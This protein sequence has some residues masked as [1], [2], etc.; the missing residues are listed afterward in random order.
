[1]SLARQPIASLDPTVVAALQA[2]MT[3]R[4]Q[5]AFPTLDFRR[6][7]FHDRVLYLSAVLAADEQDLI[8]RVQQSM[9][10][11]DI[12]ANPALADPSLVEAVLSNF[13]MALGTGATASGN[14]T[15]VVS[16]LAPLTIPAGMTFTAGG[17]TLQ[18]ASATAVRTDVSQVTSAGDRVLSRQTD[19]NYAFSLPAAASAV[20]AAGNLR[21]GTAAV[22]DQAPPFFVRAY[23]QDDWT[24]GTDA[25]TNAAA[26]ARLQTGVAAPVFSNRS[27]IAAMVGDDPTFSGLVGL[28]ILGSSDVEMTRARHGL[29]PVALP[30]YC[31][32]L[33]RTASLPV[34]TALT[35]T[36]SLV[37]KTSQG[38]VWQFSVGRDDAPGFYQATQ[39]VPFGGDTTASGY[40]IVS[41]V[42]GM[43]GAGLSY[44]PDIQSAAEAA[45]TRYQTAVIQFLDTD[46]PVGSLSVGAT[47]NYTVV[48]SGQPLLAELQDYLSARSRR[49]PAGDVLVRAAVPCDLRVSAT[50]YVPA[51][52]ASPST[53]SIAQAMAGAVNGAGFAGA[54]YASTLIDACASLMPAGAVFGPI[55][56]FGRIRRPDGVI[57]PLRNPA[58]LQVPSDPVNG[59]SPRTVS[60]LLDPANI[61][62]TVATLSTP[63]I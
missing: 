9:S 17:V 63:D 39:I 29:F 37:S 33:A 1:M 5:A 49:S 28:S 62:L 46:T 31:D 53:S 13:R 42:R 41:D 6:G 40:G 51:G 61:S 48:L 7:V 59:V 23:V 8:D 58:V 43:D 56:L 57:V 52:S 38:G 30:G 50:L 10:L 32:I 44:V 3:A 35:K 16:A 14:L 2:D 27:N 24:G 21:R 19:G 4:M 36:A 22:P 54:L 45:Y 34:R 55:D 18:T 47:Q 11:L 25:E 20:G 15:V 26:M 60:F 12:E